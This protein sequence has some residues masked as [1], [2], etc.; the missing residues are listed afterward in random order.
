LLTVSETD[1]HRQHEETLREVERLRAENEG[2]LWAVL[3]SNQ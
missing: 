2:F 3:G 1:L